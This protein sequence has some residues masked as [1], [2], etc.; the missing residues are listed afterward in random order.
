MVRRPGPSLHEPAAAP[1]RSDGGCH[2]ERYL[3]GGPK[4]VS[5]HKHSHSSRLPGYSYPDE[6][7][8]VLFINFMYIGRRLFRTRYATRY[9]TVRAVIS[10]LVVL[11]VPL[12]LQ[13][14]GL[15]AGGGSRQPRSV[16]NSR[17]PVLSMAFDLDG[18]IV[19]AVTG[20]RNER[21]HIAAFVPGATVVALCA[22]EGDVA[23]VEAALAL[24]HACDH[25]RDVVLLCAPEAGG[26]ERAAG[27]AAAP[28]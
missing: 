11:S 18:R 28:A 22:R 14:D 12:E 25:T 9:A 10:R 15:W 4:K 8:C 3:R 17:V 5:E 16:T 2:L 21:R 20:R 13:K 23:A 24:G 26:G 19:K 6:Y 1:R 27:L 7:L